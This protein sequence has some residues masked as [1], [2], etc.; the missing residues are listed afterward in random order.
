MTV[1]QRPVTGRA[2]C[3]SLEKLLSLAPTTLDVTDASHA[4]QASYFI[5]LLCDVSYTRLFVMASGKWALIYNNLR[6]NF[7]K[8]M[9]PIVML[10]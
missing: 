2:T 6:E 4:N 9:W 1:S 8:I 7:F 10:V 3:K 5:R